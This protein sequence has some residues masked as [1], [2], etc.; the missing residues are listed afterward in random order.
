MSR[1]TLNKLE[2]SSTPTTKFLEWKSNDKCFAYYDKQL[3]ESVKVELPLQVQFLEHFHTVK[4]WNDASASGIYA[5]EVKFISKEPLKVKA[6]KGGDIAEGI[7]SE[8]RGTIRDAG[9]KYYRS[10]YVVW[11][12]EIVNLQLKGACVSAY[13]D[14]MQNHENQLESAWTEIKTVSDHK[15]GATKYSTPDFTVGKLFTTK[16]MEV[17]NDKYTEI[18][19]YFNKHTKEVD[20]VEPETEEQDND[21]P[22]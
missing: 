4:G 21:L 1:R 5:N 6:F 20:V 8:I 19:N 22:F 13:S 12:G 14:F 9:G 15:K 16:E 17:A 18:A 10:V 11:K 2:G 3:K 7:Y